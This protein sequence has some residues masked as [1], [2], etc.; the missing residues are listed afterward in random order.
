MNSPALSVVIP[1]YNRRASVNAAIDSA[2]AWLD[3]LGQGEIVV[4]DDA[5]TDGTEAAVRAAYAGEIEAGR[6]TFHRLAQ[7]GGV[8]AAKNEGARRARG[9]WLVFLDSDDRLIRSAAGPAMAAMAGAPADAPLI[10]FRCVDESGGRLLGR[11]EDAPLRLDVRS[12]LGAWQWGECLPAVRAEAWRLYPYDETLRGYEA[13]AF[14]RMIQGQGKAILSDVA[15]RH[16]DE[17]GDDRLTTGV[18][19]RH[20]ACLHARGAWRLVREFGHAMPLRVRFAYLRAA[21]R[22]G[23]YCAWQR[24]GGGS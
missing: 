18:A 16:Y 20:H 24:I 13:L 7:N 8:T 19:R 1:T 9:A 5:S 15:A 11:R 14:A 2:L 12:H 4:V 17:S 3:A 22:A 23:L 10:F 6:L 21:I